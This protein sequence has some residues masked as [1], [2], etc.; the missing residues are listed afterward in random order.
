MTEFAQ[1]ALK[2]N[3]DNP[4]GPKVLQ[5]LPAAFLLAVVGVGAVLA[6]TSKSTRTFPSGQDVV[7]GQWMG[8]YEKS[9]LDPGVPWRD[10]S[11]N[12]WGG[13]NY[14]LFG[15]ARD[16]A[17]IGKDGWLFTS[18]EFQVAKTDAAEVAGKVA[19]IK[20]VRDE[21]AKDGAK[22]V[23]VLIPAKARIEADKLGQVKQPAQWQP[24]YG[25][26]RAQLEQAGIPTPDLD[27]AFRQPLEP[28]QDVFLRTDT[29]WTPDG[30]H[31]A[32]QTLAPVVRSLNLDLP[33]VKYRTGRKP[34]ISRRGDLL[35][36]VPMPEG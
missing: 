21:L 18:E 9:N 28:W 33:V 15:E 23:V 31:V 11:V 3:L 7:T 12:L 27:T 19:Y 17:V 8:S 30:A 20:Q 36:Y 6:L 10:A 34:V 16:G 5:W 1:D 22:L 4:T 14:R 32:A 24:V 25:Q 13:L 29:H 35:R 26:V 2:P